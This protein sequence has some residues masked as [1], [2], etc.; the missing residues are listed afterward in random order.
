M[1]PTRMV[2]RL[3]LLLGSLLQISNGFPNRSGRPLSK[4]VCPGDKFFTRKTLRGRRNAKHFCEVQCD[5][6][7]RPARIAED[8]LI[9][10][11]RRP[12]KFRSDREI[13]SECHKNQPLPVLADPI[14]NSI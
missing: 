14:L 5:R 6:P 12:R 1:I 8:A 2:Q 4:L 13:L 10:S 7:K 3:S 11:M 9:A